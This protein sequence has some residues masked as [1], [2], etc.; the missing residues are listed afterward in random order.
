MYKDFFTA[1]PYSLRQDEKEALLTEELVFLTQ[2]HRQGCPEY[3]NYLDALSVDPSRIHHLED[4]PFF[5]V[6]LFKEMDLK[7]VADEEIMKVTTSS[8]TTGQ[9]VSKLYIDRETAMLQQKVSVCQLTDFWGKKRLPFLIIDAEATVKNRKQYGARAAAIMGM[10]FFATKMVF[11]LNEDMSLNE[12]VLSSFLEEYGNQKFIVFGFT[13]MVWQHL[14]KALLSREETIH[15]GNAI[16]MT[17]GGWKKFEAEGVSRETFKT[18][19]GRVCGIQHFLDHYGMAEQVGSMY[20]ECECGHL[21]AS[22][23]SDI[24]TR[25][26]Q[27]LSPCDIGEP[28]IIQVLSMVPRSYPGHSLLTEDEGIIEG[29]DDCP[30]GRK[31]KYVKVLGRI[32]HAEIRGCSDTYAT[33]FK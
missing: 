9:S 23:F 26:Y 25:R 18:E 10:Q 19:L 1:G 16:L 33:R 29:I 12:A 7:S 24:I 15:M 21:H 8:G 17:G 31:G 5:P 22:V 3:R 20:C 28:G 13:F 32:K 30:C 2:R 11:A 6:R 27:D 14:Y 4:V